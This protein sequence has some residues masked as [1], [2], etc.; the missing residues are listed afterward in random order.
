MRAMEPI[1]KLDLAFSLL[2]L[3]HKYNTRVARLSKS[4]SHTGD[5]HL[6]ALM[7]ILAWCL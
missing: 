3:Q 6:Y 4:I 7:G 1:A 5:G 2:C